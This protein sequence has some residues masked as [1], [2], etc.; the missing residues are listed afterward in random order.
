MSVVIE[1][2]K[3]GQLMVFSKGADIS[4]LNKL[5]HSI[6]QPLL[7]SI[8]SQLHEFSTQGLR[9]LCFGMKLID[10]KDFDIWLKQVED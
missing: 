9:T 2:R 3:K 10:Y 4:I 1:D 5:S 6:E 8:K 7:S